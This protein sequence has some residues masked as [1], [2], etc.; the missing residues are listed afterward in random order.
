MLIVI[1]SI[2][3]CNSKCK[4]SYKVVGTWTTRFRFLYRYNKHKRFVWSS[5]DPS[6]HPVPINES[7]TRDFWLA[8]E[9]SLRRP[10]TPW[11]SLRGHRTP[12]FITIWQFEAHLMQS[13]IEARIP[14]LDRLLW[15]P[16]TSP[17]SGKWNWGWSRHWLVEDSGSRTKNDELCS[18]YLSSSLYT[19][20]S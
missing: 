8:E 18:L 2:I 7:S 15:A 19:P 11:Q 16:C 4:E 12:F 9:L 5:F 13:H 6:K 14:F 3:I 10:V 20:N 1:D 17:C